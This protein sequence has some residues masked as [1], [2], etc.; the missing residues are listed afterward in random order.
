MDQRPRSSLKLEP[1]S[2]TTSAQAPWLAEQDPGLPDEE[3]PRLLLA[4]SDPQLRDLLVEH[5]HAERYPLLVVNNGEE[6]WQ[7][8]QQRPL[9]GVVA[10]LTLSGRDGLELCRFLRSRE[11]TQAVPILLIGKQYD[12]MDAV[13]SLEV[14][15]DGYLAAP[16]W[17]P[18]VRAQLKALLRRCQACCPSLTL[19]P[20]QYPPR[21][22]TIADLQVDLIGRRVFR[23]GKEIQLSTLLFDLL[24]YLIR[25][26]GNVLQRSEIALA[27]WGKQTAAE[28]RLVDAALYR[29]RT[30]LESDPSHPFF[31]QTV[32]GIGYRFLGEEGADDDLP[33]QTSPSEPDR[34]ESMRR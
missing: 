18:L 19:F 5:L 24:V 17:W 28:E 8:A 16:L 11:A 22:L 20:R 21:V 26:R 32:R 7:A 15:A 6:A 10:E 9:L 14:G 31:I 1:V 29:L 13:V 30:R 25:R 23:G 33:L 12:S 4:V 3:Q 2:W 34:S 27:L